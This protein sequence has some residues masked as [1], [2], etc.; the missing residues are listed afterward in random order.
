MTHEEMAT[1]LARMTKTTERITRI[2]RV[3]VRRDEVTGG[4]RVVGRVVRE[5]RAN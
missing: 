4:I 1:M 2:V 5:L 3:I